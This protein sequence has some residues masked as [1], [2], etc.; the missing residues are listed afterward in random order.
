MSVLYTPMKIGFITS[1]P[2]GIL[3]YL[4]ALTAFIILNTQR[5]KKKYA[6]HLMSC[7][8]LLLSLVFTKVFL[9]MLVIGCHIFCVDIQI[10]WDLLLSMEITGQC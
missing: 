9:V 5:P 7:N 2:A 6:G 4:A 8:K 1:W 3:I 10:A